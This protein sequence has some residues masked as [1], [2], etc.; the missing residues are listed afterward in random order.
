MMRTTPGRH[1]G[2]GGGT[3]PEVVTTAS[4]KD[5][6]RA[7]YLTVGIGPGLSTKYSIRE[8]ENVK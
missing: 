1:P 4:G 2:K 7:M 3:T 6:A 8:N 5:D